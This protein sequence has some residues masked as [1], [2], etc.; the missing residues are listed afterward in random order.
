VIVRWSG[1]AVTDLKLITAHIS[2]ENP[3]A[4]RRVA[5]SLVLAGDSLEIS[6]R[7]GRVGPVFGTRELLAVQPYVIVYEIADDVDAI[8]RIWHGAQST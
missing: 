2:V 8:L 4:A 3:L 1:A 6:P 5:R 7:R